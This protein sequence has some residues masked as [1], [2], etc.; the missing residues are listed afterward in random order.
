MRGWLNFLSHP[1]NLVTLYLDYYF[2][3]YLVGAA[4]V[5][6]IFWVTK[7]EKWVTKMSFSHSNLVTPLELLLA[8]YVSCVLVLICFVYLL[9]IKRIRFYIFQVQTGALPDPKC[10]RWHMHAPHFELYIWGKKSR[11]CIFW[12]DWLACMQHLFLDPS[13]ISSIFLPAFGFSMQLRDQP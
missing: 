2:L 4:G 3:V 9:L 6:T 12:I 11:Y 10:L 7:L 5:E 13:V 8:I 1:L